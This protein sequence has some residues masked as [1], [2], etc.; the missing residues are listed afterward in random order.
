MESET[1][2]KRTDEDTSDQ[3]RD[4]MYM[5]W[6]RYMGQEFVNVLETSDITVRRLGDSFGIPPRALTCSF[7]GLHRMK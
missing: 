6:I 4:V 7:V 5:G 3:V 2:G 1:S